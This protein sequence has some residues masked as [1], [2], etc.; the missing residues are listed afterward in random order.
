MK[1]LFVALGSLFIS[2]ASFH[3][4]A[5]TPPGS[6]VAGTSGGLTIEGPDYMAVGYTRRFKGDYPFQL[7][8]PI[9]DTVDFYNSLDGFVGSDD[10][11]F[12]GNTYLNMSFNY[13]RGAEWAWA[14]GG[15]GNCS[16]KQVWVHER[17]YASAISLTGGNSITAKIS[18]RID[19][20]FSKNA[21]EGN[22][23]PTIKYSFR[24]EIC[25]ISGSEDYTSTQE[26]ITKWPEY[27]GFYSVSAR[28]SDGEYSTNVEVGVV[29]Y[30]GGKNC[31][32][33]ELD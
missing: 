18:A 24:N 15:S 12:E 25:P 3:S 14:I 32:A 7:P 6:C 30:N 20:Q 22:G 5:V 10:T 26:T 27:S 16:K 28:V 11:N 4:L 31:T 1:V 23:R 33:I 19:K 8:I 9:K 21:V 13:G 17:P 29:Q 2:S